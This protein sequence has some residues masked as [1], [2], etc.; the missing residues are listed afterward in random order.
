MRT[1]DPLMDYAEVPSVGHAPMLDEPEALSAID[2]W[3]GKLG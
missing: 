3:L 2:G 1:I